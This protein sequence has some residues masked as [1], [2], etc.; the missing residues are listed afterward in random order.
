MPYFQPIYDMREGRVIG[1]EALARGLER[2]GGILPPA[3][4]LHLLDNEGLLRL[5][6]SMLTQS[7][8]VLQAIEPHDEKLYI[9]VNVNASI[10]LREDFIEHVR[11]IVMSHDFEPERLVIEILEGE[12]I[13]STQTMVSTIHRLKALGMSVALDDVGSAYASLINIKD[14]PVDILKLDQSFSRML[15]SRPEDLQFISSMIGL[16]RG[17]NRKLVVEGAETLE[18]VEALRILGVEYAQG[19]AL[20]RPMAGAAV[21]GWLQTSALGKADPVPQTLLGVYAAH[22]TIAEACRVIA[23]QPL[24]LRWNEEA[25]DPHRCIIGKYLDRRGL[26]ETE[27]GLAHKHFHHSLGCTPESG[28]DAWGNAAEGLRK[29]LVVALQTRSDESAGVAER[30]VG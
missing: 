1:F 8:A 4:F 29:A 14:L 24:R 20:A 15:A 21:S 13:V 5:F 10:V 18:I 6:C 19:Y 3:Q 17:L 23:N 9:S 30:Q 16:A 12:E 27:Y 11:F 25:V 22:L 26:H 2:D 28:S 7:I